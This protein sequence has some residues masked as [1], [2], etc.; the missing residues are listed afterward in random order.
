[1]FN[2][3]TILVRALAL[4][5]ALFG[6]PVSS[7]QVGWK[8]AQG[9]LMTQWA[10]Q[11]SP[12]SALP[13]Y[14]RPQ[15]ARARWQNLN[16]LWDY[17]IRP[18]TEDK[19]AAFDGKILV[20]FAAESALSGVMKPVGQANRLWYRRTFER[21]AA[22]GDSRTLLHFGAVDFEATVYL[23][24]KQVGTHQGGNV[25]F[26]FDITGALANAGP[27][28]LVV[29]VWDPTDAGHQ[30]RG[31]QVDRPSGIWYTAVTGIWQT[32]WLEPV[33]PASIDALH[34]VP[35]IDAGTLNITTT[36]RGSAENITIDAVA[37]DGSRQVATATAPS[38]QPLKLSIPAARLWTPETPH[39]YDLKLT[40]R[41]GN[42][43]LDEV[44]SYFGM[45][46]IALAKDEKG[47]L[48][49]ALNNKPLFQFGPLDQGW[50]PDGLYTAPTDDA[51]KFDIEMTKKYGYNMARKHVKVEPARW[52][53]WCDRLG[54]LVW[55]DMPSGFA[56][57]GSGAYRRPEQS[58][59]QWETELREMIDA[60]RNHPSIVMWV[61]FNEG[62]GQ[63]DTV[64]ITEWV[65]SYDPTRLVNNASGWTD[66]KV[67]DVNDMHHY[68]GPNAPP[69]E[70]KR[71]AVLGEFGGLGLP[72]AG[73]TWQGQ[74]N[75]GYRNFT[76]VEDTT[77]AYLDLVDKLHV[78]VGTPG[79]AAAV[80]TQT[81]DVEIEV[82]GLMNYDRTIKFL[83]ERIA[84]ANRKVYTE[85]PPPPP[86]IRPILATSRE[87]GAPWQYTT[88][89]PAAD[90]FAPTFDASAWQNGPAGFGTRTTPNTTVRTE[91]NTGDI[92]IRRSFELPA[93]TSLTNPHFLIRHDED[94]EIYING[95]L[96]AQAT[97]YNGGYEP[98]RINADAARLLK[99]GP[100]T[101]AVHVRQTTGGQFID[102][103][104]VDVV[105]AT[106]P[107][108]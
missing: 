83:P 108:R 21:P 46:K 64:R 8:P 65:K 6:A 29:A 106:Q 17:A 93:N 77:R 87:L 88:A 27:Q 48:R 36:L 79:L 107:A 95:T 100:N 53:Y 34:L 44:T 38:G 72:V 94:V 101:I 90:W 10:A 57:G 1:M 45:R 5:L 47:V 104:I 2:R 61:P 30:P 7:A 39:L 78:L 12:D 22:W 41:Q 13:E 35:D 97:G 58:A 32:A 103:G 42:R 18:R 23:N 63:Y 69:L 70:E 85:A 24:G 67:G 86:I 74:R 49:L 4:G 82:N 84:P 51:L 37:L 60:L 56:R 25:P 91:W 50:W 89:R 76:N 43:T 54:L 33:A 73:H 92:W 31:K 16:G 75:W 28:E 40:V 26:S 55:Q 96:A 14:P 81:T 52:Y 19:P 62:W 9:P 66:N 59:S 102:V 71:A 11:V 15:M 98:L 20:P 80:Y 68:P 3:R 99:P 105:P